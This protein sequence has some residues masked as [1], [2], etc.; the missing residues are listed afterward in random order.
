MCLVCS[1]WSC[2]C[3]SL[4]MVP[5]RKRSTIVVTGMSIVCVLSHPC[6]PWHWSTSSCYRTCNALSG[7]SRSLTIGIHSCLLIV[8]VVLS[9]SFNK[10]SLGLTSS[11]RRLVSSRGRHWCLLSPQRWTGML[12]GHVGV[13][14]ISLGWLRYSRSL[15]WIAGAQ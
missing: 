4:K 12:H 11:H 10:A 3:S 7:E 14:R 15:F 5:P 6:C 2:W 8:L 13:H 1:R 9:S